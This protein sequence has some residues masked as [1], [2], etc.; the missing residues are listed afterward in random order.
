MSK[1]KQ[2]MG[3]RY[4]F[5]DPVQW[6]LRRDGKI[7][8]YRIEVCGEA[9]TPDGDMLVVKLQ[10]NAELANPAADIAAL[11]GQATSYRKSGHIDP[12]SPELW[13]WEDK[14]WVKARST[15]GTAYYNNKS[16]LFYSVN[17]KD[18]NQLMAKLYTGY[19]APEDGISDSK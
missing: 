15:D 19:E 6:T 16:Y 7:V 11:V 4:K 12:Q 8:F 14:F 13:F 1:R 5:D 9:A 17:V 2:S 18:S 10:H 3:Y